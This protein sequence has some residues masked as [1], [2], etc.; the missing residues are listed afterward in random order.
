MRMI[1]L[2]ASHLQ[3]RGHEVVVV[4]SS[5][6]LPTLRQQLK[7]IVKGQGV[8]PNP[9]QVVSHFDFLDV[10]C[11]IKPNHQPV[12]DVDVPDADVVIATWWETAEWVFQLAE[13]KGAKAYFIQHYEVFDYLPK[14]RVKATWSLPM[15]KILISQWLVNLAADSYGDRNVSYVPNGVNT[16]QFYAAPRGKQPV[17]TVGMLYSPLPWKGA[18][19]SLKA[20]DIAAQKIPDLRL[21]VFG[22]DAIAPDLLLPAGTT[23][24]QNPPQGLIKAIYASC[25]AW[26][27][28]SRFEGF[29][30]PI[31][32]AMACRTPVI[33]TPA[34]A[35]PE[36]LGQAGGF[37]VNREDPEDMAR[38]IAQVCHL[39]PDEWQRCSETAYQVANRHRC[40]QAVERFEQ[41]LYTAIAHSSHSRPSLIAHAL[42]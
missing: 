12:S 30:L 20:F 31:L 19:I 35:A 5:P 42:K 28:G 24:I 15:H 32:E 4:C 9:K 14:E 26:L 2:Y 10:A 8:I 16:E 3:K 18:D 13:A 7:S 6:P 37:L 22:E 1:A 36:L 33:A 27:F 39:S 40:E 41:A 34:G 23:Y 25:D 17:P 29:G 11:R 21:V 38:A